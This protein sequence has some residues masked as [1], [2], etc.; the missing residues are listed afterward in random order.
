MSYAS[1]ESITSEPGANNKVVEPDYDDLPR[2]DL[3][4]MW[5]VAIGILILLAVL[6]AILALG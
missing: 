1:D 5:E 6:G 2:D 3:N 4:P